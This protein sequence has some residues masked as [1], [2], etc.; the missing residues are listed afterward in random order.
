MRKLETL[1]KYSLFKIVSFV[2]ICVL[3]IVIVVQIGI[4][5]NLKTKTQRINEQNQEI[6]STL[7]NV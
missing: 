3:V 4:M 2:A 6:S 7:N 1:K 5:V